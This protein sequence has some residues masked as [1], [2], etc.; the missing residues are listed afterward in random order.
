[1]KKYLVIDTHADEYSKEDCTDTMTVGK[2]IEYLQQFAPDMPIVAG[3]NMQSVG[4]WYTYSSIT[5]G[6]IYDIDCDPK[7]VSLDNGHTYFDAEE[8]IDALENGDWGI[9]WE[10]LVN[11]MDDDAREKVSAELES[12]TRLEFLTQYLEIAPRDL[13]IG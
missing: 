10:T 11:S 3:N 6:R 5:A 8:T 9:T 7:Q 1:M 12:C 13:I 2:L 4:D